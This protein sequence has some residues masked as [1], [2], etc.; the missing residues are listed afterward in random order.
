M[1]T[2]PLF[3]MAAVVF[4]APLSAQDVVAAGAIKSY[5]KDDSRLLLVPSRAGPRP[6]SSSRGSTRCR[7]ST[8]TAAGRPFREL[9]PGR[10]ATIHYR[11]VGP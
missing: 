6:R 11:M 4:S 8:P 3:I 2:F 5:S 9:Q 1:R 10:L 7:S